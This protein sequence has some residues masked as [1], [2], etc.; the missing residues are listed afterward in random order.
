[1]ITMMITSLSEVNTIKSSNIGEI[2]ARPNE[3]QTNVN[4]KQDW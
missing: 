4:I 3:T 2:K 1:M